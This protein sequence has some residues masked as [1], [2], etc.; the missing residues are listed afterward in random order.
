MDL[1][2]WFPPL[3]IFLFLLIYLFLSLRV[4]VYFLIAFLLKN[5]PLFPLLSRYLLLR[6]P[7]KFMLDFMA[8]E[9]LTITQPIIINLGYGQHMSPSRL[10]RQKKKDRH[11]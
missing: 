8:S 11:S 7:R 5:K 4:A 9:F 2:S 10:L 3:L 6:N 1:I